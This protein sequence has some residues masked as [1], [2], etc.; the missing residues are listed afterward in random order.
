LTKAEG[1]KQTQE[2]PLTVSAQKVQ[3]GKMQTKRAI[4]NVLDFVITNINTA[5]YQN[6]MPY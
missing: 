2:N 3:Y 1:R 6:L 5:L 4:T